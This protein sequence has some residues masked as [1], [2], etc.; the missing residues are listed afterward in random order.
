MRKLSLGYRSKLIFIAMGSIIVLASLLYANYIKNQIAHKEKKEIQLWLMA[1]NSL[2]WGDYYSFNRELI[3]FV[4]NDVLSIPYITINEYNQ[5][6]D[7]HLIDPK[8]LENPKKL[9]RKLEQM[10][11]GDHPPL[12]RIMPDGSMLLVFYDDSTLLKSILYYSYIQLAVIAIFVGFAFITFRSSKHDEQNRVWIGLAKETAHQLGTPTSSLLGWIEYLKDQPI[13]QT[14]VEE[15]SKDVTRLIKV[16]NRFSK[17]GSS[18]Q[19]MPRNIYDVVASMVSYFR[20][21]IPKNVTLDFDQHATMPVQGLINDSLF[22]WVIENLLK[23]ALDAL[24]GQGN[25][26]VCISAGDKWISIEVKDTGKGMSRSNFKRIF[27]PG[28]TTKTRGWGLGLSLSKRIIEEYHHGKIF[29]KES[30]VNK[31]TTIRVMIKRL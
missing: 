17:I 4:Q 21:R 28:F 14:A 26:A 25:I 31:G 20:S 11:G 16:A 3:N 7:S 29:V 12:E 5:V 9:R 8:I 1:Y 22:E 27:E 19:L 23:N 24:Q 10:S 6:I 13:D 18:T 15:M 30:E 2:Q